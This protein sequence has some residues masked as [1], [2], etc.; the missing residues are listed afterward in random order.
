MLFRLK[1]FTGIFCSSIGFFFIRSVSFC[2]FCS[3]L[4]CVMTGKHVPWE[5]SPTSFLTCRCSPC[6][7]A[8]LKQNPPNKTEI[9][10]F[11]N[12]PSLYI[13]LLSTSSNSA[14]YFPILSNHFQFSLSATA[15]LRCPLS[16]SVALHF[17]EKSNIIEISFV[18][19]FN[20]HTPF[21]LCVCVCLCTGFAETTLCFL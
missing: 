6:F 5:Y 21:F 7:Y 17:T 14:A 9:R 4:V 15:T 13:S 2:V 18:S 20:F 16:F 19:H 12:F 1:V 8:L 11:Y 3:L 10:T